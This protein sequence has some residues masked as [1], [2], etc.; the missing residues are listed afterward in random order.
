MTA[1]AAATSGERGIGADAPNTLG[2][3]FAAQSAERKAGEIGTEHQTDQVGPKASIAIHRE[4]NAPKKPLA[5]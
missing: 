5:G 2:D 4:T 1:V 3:P